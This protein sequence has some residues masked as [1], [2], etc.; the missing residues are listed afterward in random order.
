[1]NDSCRQKRTEKSGQLL[2]SFYGRSLPRLSFEDE[3]TSLITNRLNNQIYSK[4][5]KSHVE[6]K[7]FSEGT[8]FSVKVMILAAFI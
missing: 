5:G 1:M 2:Q 8:R 7:I 3:K 6:Q 4:G